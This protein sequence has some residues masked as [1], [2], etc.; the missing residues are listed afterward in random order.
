MTVLPEF[1]NLIE[2]SGCTNAILVIASI[3][4]SSAVTLFFVL[5]NYDNLLVDLPQRAEQYLKLGELDE[6]VRSE[7]YGSFDDSA[8]DGSLATGFIGALKDPFSF[9]VAAD[10]V[11]NYN[12]L[13]AGQMEGTGLNAYYDNS[14]GKLVVSFV[15]DTSPASLGGIAVNDVI[16]S[17]VKSGYKYHPSNV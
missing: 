4:I 8:V 6:L 11:E 2:I 14:I 15:Y 5:R 1:I 13:L 3:V 10:D 17:P 12:N 7:F 9:Y 16:F